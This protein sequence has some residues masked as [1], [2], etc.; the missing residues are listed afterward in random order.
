MLLRPHTKV[1]VYASFVSILCIVVLPQ[2]LP[3]GLMLGLKAANLKSRVTCVRVADEKFAN[4]RKMVKL[5]HK[6]NSL[7]HSLDPSFPKLEFSGKD[8][9][10][11]HDF[12]GQQYALFTSEGM[13]AVT[14]VE[15]NEGIKLDGT[16]TGKAFAALIDDVKKQ[17]LRDKVVLFW[18]TYNSRDF[19]DPIAAVDYHQLPRHLH[20][21]FEE[22]VQPLDRHS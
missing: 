22:E 10:I 6:T 5:F 11:R 13:E 8:I 7:L 2:L 20:R 15:K 18:H 17:N 21:Y 16:Y 4:V 12:F 3:L 9:D 19:S 1:P 14:R